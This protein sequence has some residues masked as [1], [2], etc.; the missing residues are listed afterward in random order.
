MLLLS[1]GQ[2][3]RVRSRFFF[4]LFLALIKGMRK[5]GKF[6]I[7]LSKPRSGKILFNSITSGKESVDGGR[8]EREGVL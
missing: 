1:Q 5:H 2:V 8:R 3:I 6:K 7:S 4:F